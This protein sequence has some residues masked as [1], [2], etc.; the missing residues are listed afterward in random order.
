[1]EILNALVQSKEEGL[2][3]VIKKLVTLSI[4]KDNICYEGDE[5][6]IEYEEQLLLIILQR[7]LAVLKNRYNEDV[8]RLQLMKEEE[9]NNISKKMLEITK[10]IWVKYTEDECKNIINEHKQIIKDIE[11]LNELNAKLDLFIA[12]LIYL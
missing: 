10:I 7:D 11:K 8:D 6:L 5:K 4:Q 12:K 2:D 9:L 3:L 1:M